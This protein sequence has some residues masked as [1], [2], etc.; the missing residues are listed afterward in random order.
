[1]VTEVR[2]KHAKDPL[3]QMEH[4]KGL[5][6]GQKHEGIPAVCWIFSQV[7]V[8]AVCRKPDTTNGAHRVLPRG[9]RIE[10]TKEWR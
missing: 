7:P 9:A 6:R 1:M 2:R 4:T 5:G 10:E 3:P 8:Y